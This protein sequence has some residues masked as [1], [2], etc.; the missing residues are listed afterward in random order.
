MRRSTTTT[1]QIHERKAPPLPSSP[2]QAFPSGIAVVVGRGV[3]VEN[4]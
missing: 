4:P 3:V 2:S 1:F